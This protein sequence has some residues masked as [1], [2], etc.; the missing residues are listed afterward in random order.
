[1]GFYLLIYDFIIKVI[2][3]LYTL[4]NSLFLTL[5]FLFFLFFLLFFIYLFLLYYLDLNSFL[6]NKYLNSK[7]IYIDLHNFLGYIKTCNI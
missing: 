5:F 6:R 7:P 2:K 4:E 3:L 1:M